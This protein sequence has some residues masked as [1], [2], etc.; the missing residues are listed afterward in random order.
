MHADFLVEH[1]GIQAVV[2]P[3]YDAD[4]EQKISVSP[5]K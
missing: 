1:H 2:F 4:T 3:L 5:A